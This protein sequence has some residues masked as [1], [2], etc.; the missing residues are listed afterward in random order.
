MHH[1]N[2]H[3]TDR[4]CSHP[5]RTVPRYLCEVHHVEGW[6]TGGRTDIDNLTFACGPHHKLHRFGKVA[7]SDLRPV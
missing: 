1:L 3:F 5:G 2:S 7:S 4:G 6:A